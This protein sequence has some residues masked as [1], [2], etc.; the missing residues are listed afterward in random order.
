M[1][2][3][4]FLDRDGTIIKDKGYLG[5]IGKVEFYPF[6]FECLQK[7]QEKYLFLLLLISRA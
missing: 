3:A 2:P 4:I 1:K 6:T 7:F 5:H